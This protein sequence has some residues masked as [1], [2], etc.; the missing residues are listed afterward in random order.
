MATYAEIENRRK[1]KHYITYE[2]KKMGESYKDEY[3]IDLNVAKYL[4]RNIDTGADKSKI[5]T[6][7]AENHVYSKM[8]FVP[9]PSFKTVETILKQHNMSQNIIDYFKC[10]MTIGNGIE[11][12]V[13]KNLLSAMGNHDFQT[14]LNDLGPAC[15]DKAKMSEMLQTL[16]EQANAAAINGLFSKLFQKVSLVGATSKGDFNKI[17]PTIVNYITNLYKRIVFGDSKRRTA[18]IDI[19]NDPSRVFTLIPRLNEEMRKIDARGYHDLSDKQIMENLIMPF[20]T[21]LNKTLY[22]QKANGKSK[23]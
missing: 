7:N 8:D 20:E 14:I 21:I 3:N 12:T 13:C 23:K 19:P 6:D 5:L 17:S 16:T 1:R 2:Y 18:P 10:N 9:Q 4:V 11:D 15:R 22:Q